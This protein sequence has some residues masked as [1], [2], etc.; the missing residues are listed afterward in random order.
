[1]LPNVKT[2]NFHDMVRATVDRRHEKNL[3]LKPKAV[4]GLFSPASRMLKRFH[5][6]AE[7]ILSLMLST[8]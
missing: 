7:Q 2:I 3:L 5:C 8:L 4:D 6:C 1:M